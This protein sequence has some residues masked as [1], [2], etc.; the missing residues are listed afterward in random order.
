MIYIDGQPEKERFLVK[1]NGEDVWLPMQPFMIF[2][3]L[4]FARTHGDGWV[5]REELIPGVGQFR[6]IY[7]LKGELGTKVLI[8]NN[9]SGYYRV[10]DEVSF[11]EERLKNHP[12]HQ[13]SSLF[14]EAA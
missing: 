13:V 6:D 4:A 1:I 2:T 14:E 3:K 8:E 11:N 10:T 9:R 7:R 12:D 5:H